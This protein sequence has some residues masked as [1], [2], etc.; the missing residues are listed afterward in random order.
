MSNTALV[1]V[2]GASCSG[3]TALAEALAARFSPGEVAVIGEDAYYKR[4]DHLSMDERVTTNYDH[5]DAFDHELLVAQLE[6]L[7]RGEAID[8]P[9]YDYVMHNRSAETRRIEPRPVVIIEGILLYHLDALRERFDLK[10]FMDTP[11]DICLARRVRRDVSERGRTVDSVL[12]QYETTVR[13]MYLKYTEPS[14]YQSDLIV[15]MGGRNM[16]TLGVLQSEL[17]RLLNKSIE[18]A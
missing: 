15:P 8:C 7:Q 14:R 4:Q 1:A 13:P 3:K 18:S 9:T 16:V 2:V 10:V 11:L 5:P 12:D 17:Q 6:K